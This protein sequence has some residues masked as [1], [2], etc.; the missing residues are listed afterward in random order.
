MTW[1]ISIYEQLSLFLYHSYIF[2]LCN[3]LF[4]Y[5]FFP[6]FLSAPPVWVI[7]PSDQSALEGMSVTFDCQA[8][9]QPRPVVRWKFG[10]G[11]FVCIFIPPFFLIRF[12]SF[13]PFRYVLEC[14]LEHPSGKS[15]KLPDRYL[16][17]NF[18]FCWKYFQNFLLYAVTV[19]VY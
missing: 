3:T 2:S 5:I 8:E 4:I 17:F 1:K 9:G 13:Y 11:N 10:K 19:D 15:S 18:I 12:S 7:K 6:I 14:Y 16:S